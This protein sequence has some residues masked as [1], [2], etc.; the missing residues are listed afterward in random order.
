MQV[1]KNF[2]KRKNFFKDIEKKKKWGYNIKCRNMVS[3]DRKE[4]RK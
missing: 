1:R 3:E 4:V 2:E